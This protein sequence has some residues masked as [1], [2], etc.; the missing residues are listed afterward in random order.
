MPDGKIEYEVRAD[1]SHV[2]E[3]MEGVSSTLESSGSKW[4]SIVGGAV[5][6]IGSSL[7]G[8]AVQAAKAAW[9]LGTGFEDGMA[10]VS[11]LVNTSTTDM[12]A[13]GDSILNLSSKYGV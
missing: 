9:D 12:K 1:T 13:L 8:M 4:T 10:K 3:D 5:A 2:N 11:T 6:S 7:A